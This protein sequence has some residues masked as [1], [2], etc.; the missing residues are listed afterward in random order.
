MN[1]NNK[2]VKYTSLMLCLLL[3]LA[4]CQK[5]EKPAL[6]NYPKDTNPPG[7][8]LKFYAAF[9]GG[10]VDSIR[11]NF[12][13]P[14]NVT[15]VNGISGKAYKGGAGSYIVYPSA[16]DAAKIT[17][18]TV[19]MWINP[20]DI[21]NKPKGGA[22]S[23]FMLSRTDDFWGNMFMLIDNADA[24][25]SN[26]DSMV[27][28]FHFNGHWQE[29]VRQ[30]R[31]PKMYDNQWHHLAFTYDET[32]SKFLVYRD[33]V[34]VNLP[35]SL[36]DVKNGTAPAGAVRFTS[37]G[38]LVIGGFQQHAGVKGDVESWMY[39]YNGMLDQF[40][41]YGKALTAAEVSALF[42]SKS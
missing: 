29:L 41:I 18:F 12:G 40:K 25:P 21:S 13:T 23:L 14:H 32:T 31:L 27:V 36:T 28:K 42:A 1:F 30:Y 5:M 38:Q 8:P 20:G 2:L 37:A 16:N 39:N 24:Y 6:G 3:V 22:Q 7:G 11:A 17:S 4:A 35:A 33:G 19:S 26:T 10:D 9:D 15:Y 34:L